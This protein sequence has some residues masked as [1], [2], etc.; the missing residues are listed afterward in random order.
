MNRGI[1]YKPVDVTPTIENDILNKKK[2]HTGELSEKVF[3][4][5]T[6]GD[7]VRILRKKKLFEKN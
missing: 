1:G 3:P 5:F 6:V 7:K 4:T 2:E